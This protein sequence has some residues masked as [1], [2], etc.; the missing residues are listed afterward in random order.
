MTS[1]IGFTDNV[2]YENIRSS[3]DHGNNQHLKHYFHKHATDKNIFTTGK[4]NDVYNLGHTEWPTNAPAAFTFLVI[5]AIN[6]WLHTVHARVHTHAKQI[7][8]CWHN[9]AKLLSIWPL[10]PKFQLVRHLESTLSNHV[11]WMASYLPL[12]VIVMSLYVSCS[13][14]QSIRS[15]RKIY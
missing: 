15:A 9:I 5:G 6:I 1:W 13:F 10:H 8:N 11:T 7:R 2:Q 3:E 4:Q 12:F 14:R